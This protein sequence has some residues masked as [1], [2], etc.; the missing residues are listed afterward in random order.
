MPE[1]IDMS[2]T[3][4]VGADRGIAQAICTQLHARGERVIA[5]CLDDNPGLR[6][7]GL[8]VETGVD[9][10]SD[11][12]VQ[13]LAQR[14]RSEGLRLDC[15]LHVA[16]VLGLDRLG[17]IDFDDMRRQFEINALGPLRVV[18]ALLP[19]LARGSKVGIVT[20]RVASLADN[21][22]GGMYAYRAS[23]AA[24]NMVGLNLHHDLSPQGIAVVLLHPGAVATQLT[25]DFPQ[26]GFITADEAAAGLIRRVDELSLATSGRFFHANGSGLPW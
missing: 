16:G 2:T 5:A 23:K 4:V 22:S 14:F 10:T 21:S 11:H 20:S 3:L 7:L 24:A 9:V 6:A 12:A 19:C 26:Q 25:R 13:A 1:T 17:Q 15:L 18:Q 8:R